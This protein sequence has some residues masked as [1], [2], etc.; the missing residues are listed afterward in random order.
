MVRHARPGAGVRAL[1]GIVSF[2]APAGQVSFLA[3]CGIVL[4]YNGIKKLIDM[5]PRMRL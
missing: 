3:Y 4:I 5:R 1:I 2:V